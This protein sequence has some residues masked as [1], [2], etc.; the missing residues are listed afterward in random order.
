[1]LCLPV[2]R[3]VSAKGVLPLTGAPSSF[4]VAPAGTVQI[5][6]PD[7]ASTIG[8]GV[9]VEGVACSACAPLPPWIGGAI[10]F[11]APWLPAPFLRK[12]LKNQ[13]TPAPST[14]TA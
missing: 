10:S 11:T 12:L 9:S 4:T 2:E 8:G 7:L 13:V 5:S 6:K 1:M 3:L 14:T